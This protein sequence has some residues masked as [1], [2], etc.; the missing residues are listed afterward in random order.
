[1]ECCA[2]LLH[3]TPFPNEQRRPMKKKIRAKLIKIILQILRRIFYRKAN[4]KDE[5]HYAS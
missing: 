4:S 2:E 5:S 3:N 1:M